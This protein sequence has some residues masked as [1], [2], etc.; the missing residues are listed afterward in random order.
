MVPLMASLTLIPGLYV[1]CTPLDALMQSTLEC[2][3]QY[4]CLLQLFNRI[5]IQPL[6]SS[7]KSNYDFHTK[8]RFLIEK[9]FI[10]QRSSQKDFK[11]FYKECKPNRCSYSYNTRGN[12]AF[13]I[14]TILSLV[15]GLFVALKATARLITSFYETIA[16]KVT[17]SFCISHESK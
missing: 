11:S 16:R 6:N 2:F 4:Q 12:V 9:L 17:K 13:I 1:G 8:V 14:T 7:M 5:N 10:E 15:G 3:Y